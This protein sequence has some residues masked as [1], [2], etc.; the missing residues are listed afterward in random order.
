M[1]YEPYTAMVFYKQKWYVYSPVLEGNYE[2]AVLHGKCFENELDAYHYAETIPSD[3]GLEVYRPYAYKVNE[4]LD[5][6]DHFATACYDRIKNRFWEQDLKES[7]ARKSSL[8]C[9]LSKH[10][11]S[12]RDDSQMCSKFIDGGF[13]DG[14]EK[15]DLD[16][17]VLNC[18]EMNF[19]FSCTNYRR[20]RDKAVAWQ[21]YKK[22]K[23]DE[24]WVPA[25]LRD[26]FR[27]T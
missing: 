9:E 12:I 21:N 25:I 19:L 20:T 24:Q 7:N 6:Y 2:Q 27:Q 11:L 15:L 14:G 22:L 23:P 13:I 18:V 8:A 17:V 16:W 5:N 1:G 3:M 4:R 26:I 10:G